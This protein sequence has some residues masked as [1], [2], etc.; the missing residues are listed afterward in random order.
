MA[1]SARWAS[2]AETVQTV[3]MQ[4]AQI[5][6]SKEIEALGCPI[7]SAVTDTYPE[8]IDPWADMKHLLP[9]QRRLCRSGR[10]VGA[11]DGQFD[12]RRAGTGGHRQLQ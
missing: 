10:D 2:T 4:A 8:P 1:A 7:A 11:A 12:L 5:W 9:R 3:R 6:V